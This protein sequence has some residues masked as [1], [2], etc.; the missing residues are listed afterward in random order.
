MSRHHSA[1]ICPAGKGGYHAGKLK[2]RQRGKDLSDR[3]PGFPDDIVGGRLLLFGND[4]KNLLL[5]L[6]KV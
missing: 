5:L 1:R 6:R 3:Q 2:H 4:R